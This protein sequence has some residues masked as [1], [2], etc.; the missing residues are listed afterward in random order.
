ME[1]E[2]EKWSDEMGKSTVNV[3]KGG[4]KATLVFDEAQL[5]S[6]ENDGPG[7]NAV[8]E[9]VA[10]E[11]RGF[12]APAQEHGPGMPQTQEPGMTAQGPMP[13]MVRRRVV[14]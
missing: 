5:A 1:V 8:L 13:V 9:R 6:S 2:V 12:R 3:S 7:V 11:R 14:Q 10:M 4:K